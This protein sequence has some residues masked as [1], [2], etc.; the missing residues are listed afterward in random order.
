[1]SRKGIKH[2]KN[3]LQGNKPEVKCHPDDEDKH[4]EG[5]EEEQQLINVN[6]A[7]AVAAATAAAAEGETAA[8]AE[9]VHV[10]DWQSVVQLVRAAITYPHYTRCC[11]LGT[12]GTYYVC[13][14]T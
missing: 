10:I 1:M 6:K 3:V 14:C 13:S 2:G 7:A 4:G 11:P 8:Y 9:A 5:G 12:F